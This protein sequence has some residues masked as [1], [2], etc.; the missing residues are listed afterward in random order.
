MPAVDIDG[1]LSDWPASLPSYRLN[2][3]SATSLEDSADFQGQFRIGYNSVHNALFV[4]LEIEDDVTVLDLPNARVRMRDSGGFALLPV[5]SAAPAEHFGVWDDSTRPFM[6]FPTKQVEKT[7]CA[8]RGSKRRRSPFLRMEAG[9]SWPRHGPDRTEQGLVTCRRRSRCRWR[10]ARFRF[11][12][13]L[14]KSVGG[15][16]GT[17]WSEISCWCRKTEPFGTIEGKVAWT[18]DEGEAPPRQVR[19]VSE[20]DS[21]FHIRTVTDRNGCFMAALPGRFRTQ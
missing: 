11:L 19:I 10:P 4:S 6:G 15:F 1:D 8:M 5:H 17:A 3:V 16:T 12:H 21:S 9:C 20:A 2:S 14:G 18:D 7:V 13:Q